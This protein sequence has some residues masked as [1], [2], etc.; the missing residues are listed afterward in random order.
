MLHMVNKSPFQNG[1]LDSALR[2]ARE[3]DVIL[4]LEDGVYAAKK[5]TSKADA[6]KKALKKYKIYAI[7]ADVKA[8][9]IANV[10]DGVKVVGYD[11]FVKL[12][13]KNLT[14]SWL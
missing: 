12:V 4:L 5:G 9:G 6:M 7:S 14:H 3:D 11:K 2:F 1:A 13:E 10:V 8:R